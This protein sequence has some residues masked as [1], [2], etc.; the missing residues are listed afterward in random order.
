MTIAQPS[1]S[2]IISTLDLGPHP[3]GGYFRQTYRSS[4]RARHSV[5]PERFESERHFSTAIYYLL[6][7]GEFSAFHRIKSDEVWHFYGGGP[8]ELHLLQDDG[9]TCVTVGLALERGDRPQFVVPAGI[10]FAARP[11]PLSPYSFVGCTVSPGFDF[12]DL[13]IA[14]TNTLLERYPGNR[15]LILSFTRA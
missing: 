12:A 4:D 3:E 8:L 13:E 11:A 1:A 6:K 15:D 10:W 9:H 14:Q 7:A 5:L 2:Q